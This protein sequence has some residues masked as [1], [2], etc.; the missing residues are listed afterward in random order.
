MCVLVAVSLLAV[1]KVG[2]AL[3][4]L[5]KGVPGASL[6]DLLESVDPRDGNFLARFAFDLSFFIWAGPILFNII[7]GLLVN[8][9]W[10]L[11]TAQE[12]RREV[13]DNTCFVCGFTRANYADLPHFRGPTFE[14]H[15]DE[16][17]EFWKYVSFFVYLKRKEKTD[18]T[19][20]ETYV[21]DLIEDDLD[22]AWIPV[23]DCAAAQQAARDEHTHSSGAKVEDP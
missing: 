9:F 15:Q 14:V 1:S 21:W 18:M 23:R 10:S 5:Y 13:Y 17:H 22:L 7:T 20:A 6:G 2:C 8:G 3:L 19:G 12:A 11:T 16:T 4:L